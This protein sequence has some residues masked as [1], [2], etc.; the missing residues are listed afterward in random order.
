VNTAESFGC[1]IESLEPAT[2]Y[3]YRAVAVYGVDTVYGDDVTFITQGEG[4]PNDAMVRVGSLVHRWASGKGGKAIYQL[5]IGLGGLSSQYISPLGNR[6]PTR[7]LLPTPSNIWYM[8]TG[9][10]RN[11]QPVYRDLTGYFTF[12]EE[13]ARLYFIPGE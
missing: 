8:A 6:E 10:Y 9:E 1:L 3:H 13:G 7:T 12:D 2:T 4:F 11:G 5:E